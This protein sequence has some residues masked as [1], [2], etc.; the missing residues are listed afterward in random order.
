MRPR[1][2]N[3]VRPLLPLSRED[4]E[5]YVK[6][7]GLSFIE[8]SSNAS[9]AHRRNRL[10]NNIFPLVEEQ[11]P[12]AMDAILRTIGN[13]EKMEGIFREAVDES[14]KSVT[15]PDGIDLASLADKPFADTRLFEYLKGLNF[16]YTQ[17]CDMLSA[18]QSSGKRFYSSDG[19]VVAEI[20]RGF[21]SVSSAASQSDETFDVNPSH[22]ILS[23]CIL[24]SVRATY[25]ISM[26]RLPLPAWH[27]STSRHSPVTLI[28]SCAIT[29][30]ATEWCLSAAARASS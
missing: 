3:V 9:D 6:A 16:N 15:T 11:F 24:Q 30:A 26:L 8:D 21:L 7:L 19:N 17:A 2:A 25:P 14:I 18:A 13:L 22:D 4:I 27:I 20:N 1:S 10:R 5:D 28:G 23:R 29:D 12:G